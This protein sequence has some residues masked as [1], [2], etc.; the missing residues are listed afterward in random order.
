MRGARQGRS[1]GTGAGAGH[2]GWRAAVAVTLAGAMGVA[3]V[4]GVGVCPGIRR[5]GRVPGR[6]PGRFYGFR[7]VVAHR[8]DHPRPGPARR[9]RRHRYRPRP[10]VG[11]RVHPGQAGGVAAD[12]PGAGRRSRSPARRVTWSPRPRRA[13]PATCGPSPR[14]LAGRPGRCAGTA[15]AGRPSAGS[16]RPS[17]TRW[18]SGGR[19]VGVRPAAVTRPPR[20]LALQRPDLAAVPGGQRADRGQRTQPGQHLGGGREDR[21]PLERA[22]LVADLT[23]PGPAAEHPVLP[24][25][26]RPG[27]GPLAADVWAVGAGHCQD[28]R[29]PFYLL[30]FDG[31]RWR[32]VD[33]SARYGEPTGVVPGGSGGLGPGRGRFP[34]HVHDVIQLAAT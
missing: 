9:H 14:G 2:L 28:E 1:P 19:R 3:P 27:P 5:G 26:R 12:P 24:P 4:S 18:C 31:S 25:V 23:G 10:G 32:L 8:Q 17:G 22:R 7:G 30:H 11:V 6:G 34:R 13:R 20:H 16:A 33:R 29:G 21:G 15:A